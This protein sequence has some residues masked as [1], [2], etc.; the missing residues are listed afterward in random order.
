MTRVAILLEPAEDGG[1]SYRAIAGDKQS[2]GKTAGEALDAIT[3]LLDE[4]ATLVW[5]PRF[6]PDEFLGAAERDRLEELMARWRVARDAGETLPP[7]EQTELEAL[8]RQELVAAGR[9][10]NAMFDGA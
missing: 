10:T 1:Q 3:P 8:A 6:E 2:T 7:G 9:R 5:I 4:G